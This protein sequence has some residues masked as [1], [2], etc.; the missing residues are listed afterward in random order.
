MP[1]TSI[2]NLK[3]LEALRNL[4]EVLGVAKDA[5]ITAIKIA[6]KSKAK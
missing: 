5:M 3:K 2:Y 6:Y 4:Y 1:G